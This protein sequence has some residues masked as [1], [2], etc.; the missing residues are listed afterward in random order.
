VA[1]RGPADLPQHAPMQQVALGA[2]KFKPRSALCLKVLART[3]CFIIW[4]SV[5]FMRPAPGSTA[6]LWD[7]LGANLRWDIAYVVQ[8]LLVAAK[9]N[10][11]GKIA[12]I[13]R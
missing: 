12:P 3:V 1:G 10:I 2:E 5:Y 6:K 8:S 13:F 9:R 4:L 7:L 11:R